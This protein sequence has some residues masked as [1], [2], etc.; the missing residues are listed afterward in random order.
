VLTSFELS[1]IP[2]TF[3]STLN[4]IGNGNTFMTFNST[5]NL[6]TMVQATYINTLLVNNLF[7][8][9]NNIPLRFTTLLSIQDVNSNVFMTFNSTTNLI[10]M[11][12]PTTVS[13]LTVGTT[14]QLLNDIPVLV[15]S[16]FKIQNATTLFAMFS[17]NSFSCYRNLV[18]TTPTYPKILYNP[19]QELTIGDNN[20]TIKLKMSNTVTIEGPLNSFMDISNCIVN[21]S[22]NVT[23]TAAIDFNLSFTPETKL[24]V[25]SG[26]T[27]PNAEFIFRCNSILNINN[28]SGKITGTTWALNTLAV[29]AYDINIWSYPY[30]NNGQPD[31]NV[32]YTTLQPVNTTTNGDWYIDSIYLTH[33]QLDGNYHLNIKVKGSTFDKVVWGFKV[34]VLQ[35]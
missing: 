9:N 29:N 15:S 2:I 28:M 22:F 27:Q 16:S 17:I 12:I 21:S 35:I 18:F 8:L 31:F 19:N 10:T 11:S 13:S 25:L 26:I 32:G 23:N 6:I 4:I 33:P 3:L 24:Y 7:R 20:D 1:N 34:D 5:T 30:N 14:L